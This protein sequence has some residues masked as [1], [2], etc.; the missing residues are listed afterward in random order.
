MNILGNEMEEIRIRIA[1][2]KAAEENNPTTKDPLL[3]CADKNYRTQCF[4]HFM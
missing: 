4:Q 2:H 3:D 1:K